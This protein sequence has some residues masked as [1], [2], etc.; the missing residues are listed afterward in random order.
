MSHGAVENTAAGT[1]A[2][3]HDW[4]ALAQR[5]RGWGEELGFG[6]V[7]IADLEVGAAAARLDAWLAA[8]RHGDM[9]YLERHAEL[10]ADPGRWVPG[11]LRAIMV[12]MDYRPRD[13]GA[14]W[15]EREQRRLGQRE[16]AVVSI[17][18]RGRDYHKVL[19]QRLQQLA[20]RIEGE[21]GSFGYRV[22]TDSAPV[23]EVELARKAGIG[24]RGKH[25]L[26]LAP[27]AGSMFFVGEI[28]TDLPLPI[29]AP[30]TEHCGTC[31]RCIDICPTRAITG[32][33]ELDARRCI[34]YLTIEHKGHIAREFRAPI[35][36]RIYGCDDCLAVCPWNKFATPTGEESFAPRAGLAGPSLAELAALDDAAF[37]ARF[38]GSPVKRTGRDRF[39]RN[40]LIA[41]GNSGDAALAPAAARNLDDG[42][43]LV[44][45]MA[46][47]ALAR[48]LPRDG[49][50]A[51][52]AARRDAE[53][54]DAVRAEWDSPDAP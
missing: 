6:A 51:L 20:A 54:D 42:S 44:R 33:Y 24:W 48:L 15:T 26:L 46:V 16:A 40:V 9:D 49:F 35:G 2:I 22:A 8:G 31:E 30:T 43:P 21:V 1:A 47:W 3:G 23:L 38:A 29:D 27:D 52:R 39:V 5:I 14:D 13:S 11:A 17:Y 25:T 37:R 53:A 4:A 28:L 45:A 7:G 50:V 32:P 41:V 10:R 36:N 18:A 19:R 12:R 34:S